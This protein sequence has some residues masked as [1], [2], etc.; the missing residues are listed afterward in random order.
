MEKYSISYLS[1]YDRFT[2][3]C[4]KFALSKT[5]GNI[6][7]AN[8]FNAYKLVYYRIEPNNSN[9]LLAEPVFFNER[10]KIGNKVIT[11]TNWNEKGDYNLASFLGNTGQLLTFTEFKDKYGIYFDFV[12]YSG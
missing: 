4:S 2:L 8:V 11:C 5:K 10:I 7:W 9:D 12:T 6:F 3:L 1:F